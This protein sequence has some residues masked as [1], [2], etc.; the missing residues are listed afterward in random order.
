MRSQ[1]EL[2]EIKSYLTCTNTNIY[3][4][5]FVRMYACTTKYKLIHILFTIYTVYRWR[6]KMCKS[7]VYLVFSARSWIG[8]IILSLL[9]LNMLYS[10]C[11]YHSQCSARSWNKV[12]ERCTQ[13][14]KEMK[15]ITLHF[16][17]ALS[18]NYFALSF[19]VFALFHTQFICCL[20][21]VAFFHSL[22][23]S[24]KKKQKK[25]YGSNHM[26]NSNTDVKHCLLQCSVI[27]LYAKS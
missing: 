1:R 19:C 18:S 8:S 16:F 23:L 4:Y 9:D 6:V 15:Y 10:S 22:F 11:L 12:K 17:A 21:A 13:R 2:R 25:L 26:N 27:L 14:Q 3:I 7:M 5:V 24:V 20:V